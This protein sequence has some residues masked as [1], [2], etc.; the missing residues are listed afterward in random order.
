VSVIL[1]VLINTVKNTK[2]I[3]DLH[4]YILHYY[5]HT[6][7]SVELLSNISKS[8][9][10]SC[11]NYDIGLYTLYCVGASTTKQWSFEQKILSNAVDL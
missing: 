7:T 8:I 6:N 9:V 4:I 10:R 11:K 3:V 5:I 2:I 1:S